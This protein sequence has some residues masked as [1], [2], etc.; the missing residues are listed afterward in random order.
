MDKSLL[1][2]VVVFATYSLAGVLPF[3]STFKSTKRSDLLANGA[4]LIFFASFVLTGLALVTG[5]SEIFAGKEDFTEAQAEEL[6][7]FMQ[8][9]IFGGFLVSLLFGAVGANIFSSGLLNTD[10][11]AILNKLSEIENK[12]SSLQSSLEER[13]VMQN[14]W[15]VLKLL[16]TLGAV[17][18][19]YWIW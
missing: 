2:V 13:Q 9:I 5:V 7:N 18:I 1:T 19:L 15:V 3:W 12:I 17:F 10:N 16:I 14:N 11:S 8:Y 6:S 4:Y